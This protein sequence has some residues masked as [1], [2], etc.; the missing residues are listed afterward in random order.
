MEHMPLST[1]EGNARAGRECRCPACGK[2][3]SRYD[4]RVRIAGAVFHRRCAV[5][6]PNQAA[7]RAGV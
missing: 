5:S 2:S 1:P 7:R 3:F 4:L 6:D